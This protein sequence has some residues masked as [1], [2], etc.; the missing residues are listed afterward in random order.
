VADAALGK[1]AAE[2]GEYQAGQKADERAAV[3]AHQLDRLTPEFKAVIQPLEQGGQLGIR[4]ESV[5]KGIVVRT[6]AKFSVKECLPAVWGEG[7][8]ADG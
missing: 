2:A 5:R 4:P 8:A 1:T 7:V 6:L 3:V